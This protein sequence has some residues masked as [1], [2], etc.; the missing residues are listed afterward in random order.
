MT[1]EHNRESHPSKFIKNFP[2]TPGL[3]QLDPAQSR[4][5]NHTPYQ[6]TPQTDSLASENSPSNQKES[7]NR[8]AS[9]HPGGMNPSPS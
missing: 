8:N 2:I 7:G 4:H 1:Q 9:F 5:R 3:C 6:T